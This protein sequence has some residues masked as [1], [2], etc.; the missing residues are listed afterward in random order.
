MTVSR[1]DFANFVTGSQGV[2]RP[3]ILMHVAEEDA[4]SEEEESGEEETDLTTA[5]ER[6]MDEL[7]SVME[8]LEDTLNVQDVQ[9]LRELSASM[10]EGLATFP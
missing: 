3:T 5:F 7:A 4:S 2:T 1:T 6:E 9:D 8:E 10:Y